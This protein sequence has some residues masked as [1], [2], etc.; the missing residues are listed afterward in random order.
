MA[1]RPDLSTEA[2]ARVERA[3]TTLG[4]ALGVVSVVL[5]TALGAGLVYLVWGL[6][7]SL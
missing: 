7:A 3:A 6:A 4:I 2:A 1:P 5:L